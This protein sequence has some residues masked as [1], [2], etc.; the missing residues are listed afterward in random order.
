MYFFKGYF[1]YPD[2]V[3]CSC[4]LHGSLGLSC[5]QTGGQ[6]VCKSNFIGEKCQECA[7]GMILK[8]RID[9]IKFVFF[10]DYSIFLIVKNVNVF[11]RVYEMIFRVVV[12][13]IFQVFYVY[14]NKMLKE[15]NVIVAKKVFGI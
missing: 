4:D 6:C 15:D 12:D 8:L 14:V 3:P 7:P 10:K 11:Q 9:F 13:I 5:D 2:C 1:R